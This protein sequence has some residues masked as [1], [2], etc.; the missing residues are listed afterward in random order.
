[1]DKISLALGITGTSGVVFALAAYLVSKGLK[2]QCLAAK[3]EMSFDV[4][5]VDPNQKQ[6]LSNLTREELEILVVDIMAKHRRNSAISTG[7]NIVI[8]IQTKQPSLKE[9]EEMIKETIHDA[10][11]NMPANRSRS[12]SE[13]SHV[14]YKSHHSRTKD[15][16][17]VIMK[18]EL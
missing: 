4:H 18:E 11:H 14:S 1:M 16:H 2:S 7:N 3:M 12:G 15:D 6:T 17:I 13:E 8:P 9:I 5:Q 10:N